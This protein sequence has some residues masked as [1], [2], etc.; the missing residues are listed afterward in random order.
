MKR[1]ITIT[2]FILSMVIIC[3]GFNNV[4]ALRYLGFIDS[5]TFE[6]IESKNCVVFLKGHGF[7]VLSIA[8]PSEE[9]YL[10][11]SASK[12]N[13][14]K[15]WTSV[16][17]DTI[18]GECPILEWGLKSWKEESKNFD[19]VLAESYLTTTSTVSLYSPS[20]EEVVSL[21]NYET[22]SGEGNMR[23]LKKVGRLKYLMDWYA[24][25]DEWRQMLPPPSCEIPDD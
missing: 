6:K 1:Y 20:G 15:Q 2:I 19:K 4:K 22:Y 14:A 11:Y 10:I 17:T 7:W 24:G 21:S 5:N 13:M 23:V 12:R 18:Y 8:V 16:I 3:Q 9:G 25:D